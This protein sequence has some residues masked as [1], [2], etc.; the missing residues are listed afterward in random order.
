M[1]IHR[2]NGTHPEK[3]SIYPSTKHSHGKSDHP[4][5]QRLHL[6]S[7]LVSSHSSKS[8]DNIPQ[9]PLPRKMDE[10]FLVERCHS[11]RERNNH[12]FPSSQRTSFNVLRNKTKGSSV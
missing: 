12:H 1:D 4:N 10:S 5:L 3:P 7:N 9:S 2:G 6:P 11:P 8:M